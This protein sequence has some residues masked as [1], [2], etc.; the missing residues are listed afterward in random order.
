MPEKTEL[1]AVV[2]D[3]VSVIGE[4]LGGKIDK[5]VKERQDDSFLSPEVDTKY[6]GLVNGR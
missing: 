6:G 4:T 2:I 3:V 1:L 5:Q